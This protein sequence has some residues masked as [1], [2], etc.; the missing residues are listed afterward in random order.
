HIRSP[1]SELATNSA[2]GMGR[3]RVH[4]PPGER[5]SGI[6]DS[7]E[8]PAPV[9]GTIID[10]SAIISPS[11]STPLRRPVEITR[12]PEGQT[13]STISKPAEKREP[14]FYQYVSTNIRAIGPPSAT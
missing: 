11:C 5:K 9:K 6:P 2:N 13:V 3:L 14:V 12:E 10:A 4:N 7:V 8:M 1:R